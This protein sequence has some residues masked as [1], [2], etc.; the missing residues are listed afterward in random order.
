MAAGMIKRL[1]RRMMIGEVGM[2][3]GEGGV[4]TK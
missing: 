4:G 3:H 2:M 1:I